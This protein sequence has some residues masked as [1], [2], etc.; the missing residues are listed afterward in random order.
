MCG[1]LGEREEFNRE[2]QDGLTP[3]PTP[4][5]ASRDMEGSQK[6]QKILGQRRRYKI[7]VSKGD[8]FSFF[9]ISVSVQAPIEKNNMQ[10]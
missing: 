5:R 2:F 1:G 7:E 3:T 8:T 9:L 10:T 4:P 6:G